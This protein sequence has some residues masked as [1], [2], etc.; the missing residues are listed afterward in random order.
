MRSLMWKLRIATLWVF[1]AVGMVLLF[2]LV[3]MEPGSVDQLRT[4]RIAEM[5]VD[6]PMTLMMP[7]FVLIPL[8]LAFLT[9][10]LT[11]T[12][13]RW[14]NVVAGAF[15]GAMMVWDVFEHW[16]AAVIAAPVVSE[17]VALA[18]ILVV[19]MALMKPKEE[20]AEA[21]HTDKALAA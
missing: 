20:L 21:R 19:V 1:Y 15:F 13:A 3:L 8:A 5:A 2:I 14:V 11:D 6:S 7:G 4:G 10:V 17:L 12:V 9:F 18:G 16:G